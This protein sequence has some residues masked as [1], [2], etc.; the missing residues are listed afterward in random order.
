MPNLSENNCNPIFQ[1]IICSEFCSVLQ[2]DKCNMKKKK[3]DWIIFNSLFSSGFLVT[4]HMCNGFILEES[5][6]QSFSWLKENLMKRPQEGILL[7]ILIS[8]PVSALPDGLL[9]VLLVVGLRP[10]LRTT[11]YFVACGLSLSFP[12]EDHLG[13]R[14]KEHLF[15][16]T[17]CSVSILVF[18]WKLSRSMK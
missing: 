1:V 12:S 6:E 9:R 7:D 4:F 10:S 5:G 2:L 18:F 16:P 14:P 3:K 17:A 11:F 13:T 8:C 15:P